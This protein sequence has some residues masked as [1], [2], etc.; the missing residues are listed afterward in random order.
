MEADG[1]ACGP[2]GHWRRRSLQC[3][4]RVG[5]VQSTEHLV[6]SS[7]AWDRSHCRGLSC[8]IWRGFSNNHSGCYVADR[9][10]VEVGAG[11]KARVQIRGSFIIKMRDGVAWTWVKGVEMRRGWILSLFRR[12]LQQHFLID[13]IYVTRE[14]EESWM[15]TIILSEH[16]EGWHCETGKTRRCNGKG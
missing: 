4:V 16:L 9:L 14:R 6:D 2:G 8:G 13:W 1:G 15:T 7:S 12:W 3:W 10:W 11:A 5:V